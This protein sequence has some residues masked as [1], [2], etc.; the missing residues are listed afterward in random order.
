M[1]YPASCALKMIPAP[2]C[3]I[4]CTVIDNL[5]D[6]GTCWRL[7]Q[8]LRHDHGKQVRLF[9]DDLD[10]LKPLVP[11]TQNRAQQTLHGIDVRHWTA[12]MADIPPAPIVIETFGCTLPA[13]YVQ[14]MQHSPPQAWLN[15]EYMSCEPWVSHIHG[16]TSLL[17]HGLRKHFIIPSLLPQ[18]GGLLREKNLLTQRDNFL[19]SPAQQQAWCKERG[20]PTPAA[21]SLKL[22]LFAYEN[23]QLDTLLDSLSRAPQA[24]T[25]YLPASRLLASLGEYLDPPQLKAGDSIQL[26]SLQLHIL[27]F[28]P[29]A[30][31]DRLLWL[32]DIN[33]VRGEESLTRALWAGKPLIWHIYPTEDQAHHTKL[34]AFLDTY[35]EHSQAEHLIHLKAWMQHWNG[36]NLHTSDAYTL[37]NTLHQNQ[38]WYKARSAALAQ[39]PD[40]SQNILN[41]FAF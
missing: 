18:S 19:A 2:A 12:N 41:A 13:P 39:V 17:A 34:Q 37:L 24:I 32:C 21:N 25:A 10:A 5:G 11:A 35:T 7:A 36:I 27:P 16:Q 20:I 3:D 4:F 6:I 40:L 28:L 1:A 38:A 29:Q 30:E 23:P 31:Y 33:F 8:I 22:S 26:G 15:L 14:A 9:V